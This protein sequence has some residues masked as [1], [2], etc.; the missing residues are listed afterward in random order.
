MSCP[1]NEAAPNCDTGNAQ[2][3]I[4]LNFEMKTAF[5]KFYISGGKI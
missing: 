1:P 2:H 3:A 5:K 4:F